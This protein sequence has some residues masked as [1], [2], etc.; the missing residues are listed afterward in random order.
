MTHP[1]SAYSQSRQI[2]LLCFAQTR[3]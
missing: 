2:V 3:R 1:V